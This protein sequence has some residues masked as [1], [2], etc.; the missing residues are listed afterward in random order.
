MTG[1]TSASIEGYLPALES[2]GQ[3]CFSIVG[4]LDDLAG[5]LLS[6]R[7]ADAWQTAETALSGCY[8]SI[9]ALLGVMSDRLLG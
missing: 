9:L 5:L 8:D 7:L 2:L 3:A 1:S 4:L 6:G